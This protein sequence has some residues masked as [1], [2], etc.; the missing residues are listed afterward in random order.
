MYHTSCCVLVYLYYT[1]KTTSKCSFLKQSLSDIARSLNWFKPCW[2]RSKIDSGDGA[3]FYEYTKNH[4]IVHFKWVTC[5][6]RELLLNETVIK[7][8]LSGENIGNMCQKLL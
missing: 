1:L 2:T 5:T 4:C 3:R 8:N 7:K 6:V